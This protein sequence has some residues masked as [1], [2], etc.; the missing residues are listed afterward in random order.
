LSLMFLRGRNS[1]EITSRGAAQGVDT[2]PIDA[3]VLSQTLANYLRN[4][5]PS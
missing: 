5:L 4:E 2:R 1:N 3:S